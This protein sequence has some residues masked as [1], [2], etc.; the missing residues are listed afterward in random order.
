MHEYSITK[1]LFDVAISQAE[2]RDGEKISRLNIQL[3]PA[4]TYVPDTIRF[5]FVPRLRV[6]T[7]CG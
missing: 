5:Y 3:D 6:P 1:R 2:L 7:T 4:S